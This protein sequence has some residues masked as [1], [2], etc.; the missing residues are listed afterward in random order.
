MGGKGIGIVGCNI[1]P[2]SKNQYFT[3]I[4]A[5]CLVSSFSKFS[6]S[7]SHLSHFDPP[8]P[9]CWILESCPRDQRWSRGRFAGEGIQVRN[10]VKHGQ[11]ERVSARE[12]PADAVR[13]VR[14]QR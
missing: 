8:S 12:S 7:P 6:S 2:I 10:E 11:A 9:L 13:G 4:P 1:V 5:S 3:H 14:G